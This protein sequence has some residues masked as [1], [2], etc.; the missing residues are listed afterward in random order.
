[1]FLGN[2]L[3]AASSGLDSIER[4]LALV[5]QNVANAS[6]P[7]YV[8]ETLPLTSLETAGGPAGVRSGPATRDMDQALQ[9]Q[10][11]AAVGTEAGSNVTQSA[12]QG[13]DQV[14]GSPGGGQDIASLLG[15]LQDSFSTLSNDPSS[16]AQQLDVLSKAGALTSGIHTLGNALLQARQQAQNT[17]VQDVG[18]VN[19]ALSTLG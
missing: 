12:L 14:S 1:M 2:T 17:L 7:N 13:I 8:R 9:G 11:F 15:A 16:G 18:T 3:N 19:S 10:L 5:S 4:Q 6:T